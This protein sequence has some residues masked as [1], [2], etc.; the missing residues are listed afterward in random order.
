MISQLICG[1]GLKCLLQESLKG[2]TRELRAE[3]LKHAGLTVVICPMLQTVLDKALGAFLTSSLFKVRMH[4]K[5]CFTASKLLIISYSIT[6]LIHRAESI[7]GA[8][9]KSATFLKLDL[10]GIFLSN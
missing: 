5:P 2:H 1:Q 3:I 10:P 4:E 6:Q 8:S 7:S 9:H